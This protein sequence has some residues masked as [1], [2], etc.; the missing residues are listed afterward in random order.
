MHDSIRGF[1]NTLDPSLKEIVKEKIPD[2]GN[3]LEHIMEMTEK[4]AITTLDHVEAMQERFTR[5][6]E[7]I[8]SLRALIGGLSA[9]G[10]S[11]GKK[12]D[13]SIKVSTTWKR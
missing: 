13:E 10:D 8:S 7:Q 12:L 9:I 11:A 6:V 3:R 4:A 5:E 2:S 1:L